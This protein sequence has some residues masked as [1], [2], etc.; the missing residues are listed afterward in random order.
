GFRKKLDT[1]HTR[2]SDREKAR[3]DLSEFIAEANRMK[4]VIPAL[5]EEGPQVR[6][7]SGDR[8]VV[9]LA[10]RASDG[11]RAL[12]LVNRSF[13]FDRVVPAER[14]AGERAPADCVEVTPGGHGSRVESGVVLRMRPLEVRIFA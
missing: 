11:S 6:L 2:P 14:L 13:R 9:A 12:T 5:N 8:E 3:F 1:V 4:G 7:D 10:R